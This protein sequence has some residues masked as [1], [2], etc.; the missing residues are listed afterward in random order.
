VSGQLAASPCRATVGRG[1]L[2]RSLPCHFDAL[3][4]AIAP[5]RDGIL[6][7]VECMFGGY[8]LADRCADHGIPFVVGHAMH[9]K[10]IHGAK[11]KNDRLDAPQLPPV[12]CESSMH[13][14]DTRP[15]PPPH[16]PGPQTRRG[17]PT[18]LHQWPSKLTPTRIDS[19]SSLDA[20]ESVPCLR[21]GYARDRNNMDTTR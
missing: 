6:I 7:G 18:G 16:V 13:A 1:R 15:A 2:D 21:A 20:V 9:M 8:W 14:R 5:F 12:V 17:I 4:Q 11:A 19:I 3:L 10:L